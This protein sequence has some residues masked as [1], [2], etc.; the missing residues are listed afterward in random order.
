VLSVERHDDISTAAEA[1]FGAEKIKRTEEINLA[2]AEVGK[3]SMWIVVIII[4]WCHN[5]MG[6]GALN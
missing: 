6:G 5:K 1:A 4:A 2:K 3:Q